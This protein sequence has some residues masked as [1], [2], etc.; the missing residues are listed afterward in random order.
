MKTFLF[1]ISACWLLTTYGCQKNDV[2]PKGAPVS[3]EADAVSVLITID[4]LWK[5]VLRP[6]LTTKTQSFDDTVL[7]D[8]PGGKVSV[9]GSFET[10]HASSSWSSSSSSLVDVTVTFTGYTDNDLYLDGKLRFFDASSTRTAC[11][12]SGCA[13]SSH[14][15]LEYLSEDARGNALEAMTIAFKDLT[16]KAYRDKITLSVSKQYVHWQ[17]SLVNSRHDTISVIY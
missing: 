8:G 10:T 4:N 16:G 6:Q 2:K 9:S 7:V 5:T 3:D 17:G 1:V 14:S 11:S 15:D 12:S 13:S